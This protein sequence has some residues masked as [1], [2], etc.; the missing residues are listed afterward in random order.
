MKLPRLPRKRHKRAKPREKRSRSSLWKPRTLQEYKNIWFW[1]IVTLPLD[2]IIIPL[3]TQSSSIVSTLGILISPLLLFVVA[4]LLLLIPLYKST[5]IE[6]LILSQGLQHDASKFKDQ[7][8]YIASAI[9]ALYIVFSLLNDFFTLDIWYFLSFGAICLLLF[10]SWYK[11]MK[12][13][14]LAQ[15][16][17]QLSSSIQQRMHSSV[18]Q[19][20]R[21]LLALL[22]GA[23]L[24]LP[25]ILLSSHEYTSDSTYLTLSLLASFASLLALMPKRAD[26][27]SICRKCGLWTRKAHQFDG[28]C[29]GCAKLQL[30]SSQNMPSRKSHFTSV[31]KLIKKID[32]AV[33]S[34]KIPSYKGKKTPKRRR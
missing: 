31:E 2:L 23:R 25:L 22:L 32:S 33:E 21:L 29:P 27:W 18:L 9:F 17:P 7:F 10:P 34:V 4:S 6:T 24:A 3:L 13:N 26:L 14:T 1:L 15:S 8:Q 12:K 5:L 16:K 11:K 20:D 19:L 28:F 30:K